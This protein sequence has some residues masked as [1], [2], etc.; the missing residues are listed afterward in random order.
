MFHLN[1]KNITECTRCGNCCLKGGPALHHEDKKILLA[2]CAGHQHLVTIRKGE[3]AFN[4]LRNI[5]EPVKKELIKVKGKGDDWTCYF[6]DEKESSCNIYENR[7]LECWLLK[8]WDTSEIISLIGKNTIAR[9]DIIN[10]GDPIM[11]VIEEH[12]QACPFNE[13]NALVSGLYSGKEK[14][15]ILSQLSEFVRNDFAIRSYA[16]A[17][18]GLMEEFEMF[19]FGRPLYKGLNDR[20]LNVRIIDNDIHVECRPS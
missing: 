2:G 14:S 7:F 12:E 20:G 4:P 13:I 6:Y 16:V 9:A 1:T 5:L 10:P 19:I 15:K 11:K 8:C 18:L 3:M 17:E